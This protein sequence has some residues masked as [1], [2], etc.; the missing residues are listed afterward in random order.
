M[1]VSINHA[2]RKF[3]L[4][5]GTRMVEVAATVV[6]SDEEQA[7]IRGRKLKDYIVLKREP[8][9]RSIDRLGAANVAELADAYHLRVRSLLSGKPDTYLFDT[10]AHAKRYEAELT[11]ALKAFKDFI[12]ANAETASA[13]T[14]EL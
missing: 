10:P 13:T 6:F 12:A 5:G 11:D 4:F 14:F 2:D 7:I 1:R 8:D 3:G 9:S